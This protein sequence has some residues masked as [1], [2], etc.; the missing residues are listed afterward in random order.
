MADEVV[1]NNTKLLIFSKPPKCL[2]PF[3]CMEG[4]NV[5]C[6]DMCRETCANDY[7]V[8]KY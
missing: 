2:L 4:K 6:T 1:P 5:L 8:G 7:I 3:L